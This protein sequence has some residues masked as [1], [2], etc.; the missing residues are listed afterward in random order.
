MINDDGITYIVNKELRVYI[1]GEEIENPYYTI[2]SVK[3]DNN[4]IYLDYNIE[5]AKLESTKCI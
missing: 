4:Y 3:D 2:Y 5:F 1:F